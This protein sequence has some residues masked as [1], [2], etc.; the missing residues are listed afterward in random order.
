MFDGSFTRVVPYLVN[1]KS[2]HPPLWERHQ[3]PSRTIK[4]NLCLI[5][6]VI[7]S[8]SVSQI[9]ESV[10]DVV[11]TLSRSLSW[12]IGCMGCRASI[13]HASKFDILSSM[14]GSLS[15]NSTCSMLGSLNIYL[16]VCIVSVSVSQILLQHICCLF[17]VLT[18]A[19]DCR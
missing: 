1:H 5:A 13:T 4:H 9:C 6:N 3:P 19:W 15:R 7:V 11:C 2:H 8:V 17:F 16:R 14:P 18:H 12:Y 10:N